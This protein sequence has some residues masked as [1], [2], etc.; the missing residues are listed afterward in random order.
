M[1]SVR[2]GVSRADR[3]S[4]KNAATESVRY[5][6]RLNQSH[7][8]FSDNHLNI[9]RME[10]NCAQCNALHFIGSTVENHVPLN[11]SSLLAAKMVR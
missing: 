7:D 2:D 9:P 8:F 10:K 4:R 3:V 1:V 6:L 5:R 11:Q